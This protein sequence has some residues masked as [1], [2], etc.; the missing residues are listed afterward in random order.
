MLKNK[1]RIVR[2]LYAGYE[3]QVRFWW[4]PFLWLLHPIN[5]HY[6]VERAE[7][8]IKRQRLNMSVV[9]YID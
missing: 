8:Y 5:T 3:V 6:S 1:Y 7:E 9:K 4:L 2:D